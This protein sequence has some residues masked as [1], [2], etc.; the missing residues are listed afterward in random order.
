MLRAQTFAAESIQKPLESSNF[1]VPVIGGHSGNTIVPLFSQ[2]NPSVSTLDQKTLEAL[3]NRVQFGGDEVVK[4][5]DGAGSATLSMA[6]AGYRFAQAL[7][8][9]KVGG[10]SGISEMACEEHRYLS[11]LKVAHSSLACFQMSSST[12]TSQEA[13]TFRRNSE[14]TWTSSACPLSLMPMVSRPSSLLALCKSHAC[15][16]LKMRTESHITAP[17][18]RRSCSRWPCLN[19]RETFQR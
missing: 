2:A 6:A 1:S 5:K 3:T 19:Y 12:A 17:I 11:R 8:D 18:T 7:L 10:K 13:K 15:C 9:A 14:Q 4:A 16:P